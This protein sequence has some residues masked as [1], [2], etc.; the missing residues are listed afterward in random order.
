[1]T[2]MRTLQAVA[3]TTWITACRTPDERLDAGPLVPDATSV[4]TIVGQRLVHYVSGAGVTSLPDFPEGAKIS[5]LVFDG[6]THFQAIPGTINPD[7]TFA[8]PRVPV[9][10]Y[11]LVTEA[12]GVRSVLA[13]SAAAVDLSREMFGRPGLS[14]TTL[15]AFSL[16]ATGLDPWQ[17]EDRFAVGCPNTGAAYVF[18]GA[19]AL[20]AGVTDGN[21]TVYSFAGLDSA[22]GD[23]VYALQLRALPIPGGSARAVSRAALLAPFTLL[24][25]T[26]VSTM[27]S[28]APQ[29]T[30]RLTVDQLAFAT[31]GA[32]VGPST[33]DGEVSATVYARPW[34]VTEGD[35]FGVRLVTF[36]GDGTEAIDVDVS[37]GNPFPEA[38]PLARA[39]FVVHPAWLVAPDSPWSEGIEMPVR[40]WQVEPPT[41]ATATPIVTP[42]RDLRINGWDAT[43]PWPVDA[44]PVLSWDPPPEGTATGYRVSRVGVSYLPGVG[45]VYGPT[46][47]LTT[48]ATEVRFPWT[49]AVGDFT[50]FVVTAL[51]APGIDLTITPHLRGESYAE[52]S[53]ITAVMTAN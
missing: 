49:P 2:V 18:A 39:T 28:V 44:D 13:T 25:G 20:A 31:L 27:L 40:T 22:L 45:T 10:S 52:S 21:F 53:A 30:F 9:G 37:F 23:E 48:T 24:P 8:I 32:L 36:Q 50:V 41:T 1:M 47:Q 19:T 34:A 17:V 4:R 11:L 3:L 15:R 46:E 33:Y 5:A 29:Q 35:W 38:W 43:L 51:W 12:D 14:D 26:S 7:G 16:N 42:V 6:E